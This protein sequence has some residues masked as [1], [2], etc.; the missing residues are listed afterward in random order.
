MVSASAVYG[1][2]VGF[3]SLAVRYQAVCLLAGAESG[4]F[5]V[6]FLSAV[7][8]KTR[9][10]QKKTECFALFLEDPSEENERDVSEKAGE[11][12]RRILHEIGVCLRKAY[13]QADS[14][15]IQAEEYEQYVEMWAHEVKL[16][17]SLFT[18]LLENT[19]RRNISCCVQKNGTC[20]TTDA[21][22]CRTD[23]DVCQN[24]IRQ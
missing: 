7:F 1:S 5:A 13:E 12:E 16:P 6:I 22:L 20:Q 3:F 11:E 21:A 19:K 15:R 8:W 24:K 10:T 17:L 2:C 4:C 18:L 23:V 9:K 14:G